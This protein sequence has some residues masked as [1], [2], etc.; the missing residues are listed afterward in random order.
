MKRI[1]INKT[2][3]RGRMLRMEV[4]DRIIVGFDEVLGQTLRQYASALG[5]DYERRYSVSVNRATRTYQVIR[6]A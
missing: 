2:S 3:P 6:Y 1:D 5:A 4:G